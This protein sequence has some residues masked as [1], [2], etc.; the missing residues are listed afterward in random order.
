MSIDAD[1]IT[2]DVAGD[3][4]TLTLGDT[5]RKVKLPRGE[6]GAP[7]RDGQSRVR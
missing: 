2:M 6:R 4:L 3:V 5:S 7:G 1:K